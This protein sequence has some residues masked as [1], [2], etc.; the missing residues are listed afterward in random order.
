MKGRAIIQLILAA[1]MEDM[2]FKVVGTLDSGV[3]D[4]QTSA[5][6]EELAPLT[7][8]ETGEEFVGVVINKELD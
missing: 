5:D 4:P 6:I 7:N 8:E 1:R 2:D 3:I